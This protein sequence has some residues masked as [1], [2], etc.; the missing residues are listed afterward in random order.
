MYLILLSE[1]KRIYYNDLA[2]HRHLMAVVYFL[3]RKRL[4]IVGM[5]P[6]RYS[7]SASRFIGGLFLV[8]KT[9]GRCVM[10]N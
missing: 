8:S 10:S 2:L 1:S 9:L 4:I 5:K 7:Y 6:H 3:L